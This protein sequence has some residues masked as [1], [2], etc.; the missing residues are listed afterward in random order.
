MFCT[1]CG[2]ELP[3]GTKFCTTCGHPLN[4]SADDIGSK[5]S[6]DLTPP[7]RGRLKNKKMMMGV[8]TAICVIIIGVVV[9]MIIPKM[10]AN[11]KAE[12]QR[13]Q[14]E[15]QIQNAL[16]NVKQLADTNELSLYVLAE[17]QLSSSVNG[18][19]IQSHPT[20]KGDLDFKGNALHLYN[21]EFEEFFIAGNGNMHIDDFTSESYMTEDSQL[22]RKKDNEPFI[23]ISEEYVPS[24]ERNDFLW[25]FGAEIGDVILQSVDSRDYEISDGNILIQGNLDGFD[26]ISKIVDTY[27]DFLAVSGAEPEW[28]N[29]SN[30]PISYEVSIPV[31]KVIEDKGEISQRDDTE[32]NPIM[33]ITFYL[34]DVEYIWMGYAEDGLTVNSA[35]GQFSITY[36]DR[37]IA[38]FAIP[39]ELLSMGENVHEEVAPIADDWKPMYQSVLEQSEMGI[40]SL[41]SL[42]GTDIPYLVT[43]EGIYHYEDENVKECFKTDQLITDVSYYKTKGII[44]FSYPYNWSDMNIYVDVNTFQIVESCALD[45]IRD[46]DGYSIPEEEYYYYDVVTG[47][48]I[49]VEQYNE[50]KNRY[51]EAERTYYMSA[52]SGENAY[53]SVEEAYGNMPDLG[54][55]VSASSANE[56]KQLYSENVSNIIGDCYMNGYALID[57][58]SDG[59]PELFCR[60]M[61]TAD[62]N[63]LLYISDYDGTATV[64]CIWLG[65]Y[66]SYG[67]SIIYTDGGRMGAYYD[68]I[69]KY[70]ESLGKFIQ[71]F[72]GRWGDKYDEGAS[73]IIQI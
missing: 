38:D 49:T 25:Y 54:G 65:E 48:N 50:I 73:C 33:Q 29:I 66:L 11:N 9:T 12:K 72:A 51:P 60:G 58:T 37:V 47:N 24:L 20:M 40:A 70:D 18:E 31:P 23:K 6:D 41:F 8:I 59:V 46:G 35:T 56:W 53:G 63:P 69:Y 3:E 5:N 32:S 14:K 57:I 45:D 28:S 19:S 4:T 42:N 13:K 39:Q 10:I 44:Q 36:Y 34:P 43:C 62:G 52:M 15:Q 68:S 16:E 30:F 64:E 26:S 21:A 27:I 61:S 55:K 22:L 67:E 1:K 7:A 17:G 71:T 2:K